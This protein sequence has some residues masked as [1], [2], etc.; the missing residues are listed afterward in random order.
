M[1][2]VAPRAYGMLGTAA[3]W[4]FQLD[5][6]MLCCDNVGVG[7]IVHRFMN[8]VTMGRSILTARFVNAFRC[9][10]ARSIDATKGF[11]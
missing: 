7:C 6:M 1:S 9:S 4:L 5:R 2:V 8:P 11:A 3:E 10:Q